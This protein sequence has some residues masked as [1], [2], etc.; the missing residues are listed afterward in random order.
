MSTI[1]TGDDK[2]YVHKEYTMSNVT[3]SKILIP[4][5]GSKTSRKVLVHAIGIV[6]KFKSKLYLITAVD[7]SDFPPRMLLS[8]LSKDK[9]LEK[10]IGQ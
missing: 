8:L 4:L 3:F 1:I 6:K 9:R 2:C 5:D 7:I 10:P